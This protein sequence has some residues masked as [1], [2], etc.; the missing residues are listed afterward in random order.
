MSTGAA[1]RDDKIQQQQ[2]TNTTSKHATPKSKRWITGK[3][4][5]E[6]VASAVWSERARNDWQRCRRL[7]PHLKSNHFVFVSEREGLTSTSAQRR[8][9][10]SSVICSTLY[11]S[12][13]AS[14]CRCVSAGP[15]GDSFNRRLQRKEAP[16]EEI[17]TLF[18]C[19][20]VAQPRT[21]LTLPQAM[22]DKGKSIRDDGMCMHDE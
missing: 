6:L 7:K 1:C 21:R 12:A 13:P 16:K 19:T 18:V 5:K 17:F 14:I 22:G 20:H 4:G 9:S 11:A 10:I 3:E 2:D 8:F 15:R